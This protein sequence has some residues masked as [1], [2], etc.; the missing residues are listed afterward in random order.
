MAQT[1]RSSALVEN[2]HSRLRNY[3]TLRRQLGGSYLDLLQFFL[4]RR[5]YLRSRVSQRVGNSPARLMTGQDHSHWL[6]LLGLG[7][8][9]PQLA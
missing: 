2:L 4:N 7:P 3:F 5:C 8:L 6:T 9:Q 1:P